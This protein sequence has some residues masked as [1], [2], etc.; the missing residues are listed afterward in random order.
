MIPFI[1][2]TP[3][4]CLLYAREGLISNDIPRVFRVR[5]KFTDAS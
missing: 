3:I 5:S 4:E 2:P 1:Y